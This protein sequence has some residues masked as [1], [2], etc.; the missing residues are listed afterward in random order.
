HFHVAVH[1]LSQLWPGGDDSLEFAAEVEI[2]FTI[3]LQVGYL[4][5]EFRFVSTAF[6]SIG[7]GNSSMGCMGCSWLVFN[8]GKVKLTAKSP[9]LFV[10]MHVLL[11]KDYSWTIFILVTI[12]LTVEGYIRSQHL[13]GKVIVGNLAHLFISEAKTV[14]EL[15][16][17]PPR[18]Y[19]IVQVQGGAYANC[20]EEKLRATLISLVSGDMLNNFYHQWQLWLFGQHL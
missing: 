5:L 11:T 10:N 20:T 9:D 15:R 16:Q 8:R 1:T 6:W 7:T 17:L 2:I 13:G 12:G 14:T 4:S 19:N 3:M 18:I